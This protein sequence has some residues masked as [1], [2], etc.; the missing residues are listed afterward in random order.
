[1]MSTSLSKIFSVGLLSGGAL[2]MAFSLSAAAQVKTETS[3]TEEEPAKEVTIERGEIVRIQGNNVVVK[4]QDGTLRDF[5]NVPEGVSFVVDGKPVNIKNAQVGMK[6]EKQTVTTTTP[7]VITT[8]ETV[9]GKVWRVQPPNWVILTLEN[10]TNQ[11]FNIPQGQ[12]FMVNGKETDAFGLRKGMVINAQRVTE[13]PETVITQQVKRTGKMPPPPTTPVKQ[14]VPILIAVLLPA[15][16]A[17]APP[18]ETATAERAPRALPKT[19]SD[20]PFVGLLGALICAV[21]L[22]A[23]G[24]RAVSSHFGRWKG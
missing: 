21:S 6:L 3:V 13:V 16:Q 24:L 22:I 7:R 8:I 10:G 12:K 23:G 2:F 14:D 4:M 20:L 5:H 18:V 17:P 19:G 9:S 1:M 11:R 15:P